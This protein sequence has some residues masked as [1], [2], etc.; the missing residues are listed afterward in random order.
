[1]DVFSEIDEVPIASASLAQVHRP[2]LRETGEE[3]AVKLQYPFLR[4]QMKVDLWV[5][6]QLFNLT[7]KVGK[8]CGNDAIDFRNMNTIFD[9]SHRLET[10][11]R[12]ELI[13]LE[14]TRHNFRDAVDLYLPKAYPLYS[15]SRTMVMEWVRGTRIDNVEEIRQ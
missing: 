7:H 5:L 14:K 3:V 9:K 6:K 8:M 10:D 2:I 11:F 12:R 4:T 1:M 13:N 15:S